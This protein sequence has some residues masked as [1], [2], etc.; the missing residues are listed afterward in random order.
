MTR[1]RLRVML[2]AAPGVGKTF[3]MLEEGRRLVDAGKDVVVAVV[4]THGRAATAALLDGLEVR[5]APHGRAPR[6]RARRDGPRRRARP[7]PRDRPRRRARPHQRARLP[8]REALAGRRRAARRRHRRD[9]DRQHPAH[10]VAQRRRAAD[11]RRAAARDDPG[12]GAARRRPDRARRPRP[13]G[14]A[15]PARGGPRLPGG[16]GRCGALQLLPA[17]QPH[18]AARTRAALARRRGRQRAASATAPSRASTRSGRRA[19]ASSSPSPAARRARPCC[20]AAPASP[21][22]RPA[23]SSSRC[24]STS[25]DGLREA[26]PGALAAQRALVEQLGGTYHQVVGE[27]VPAR[28]RRLRAGVGRHPA[29]DRRQPAQPARGRCS[30]GRASARPS[31][32]SPAT[33]TCTS[34]RTRRPADASRCRGSAAASPGGAESAGF[35]VALVVGPLLTR[36]LAAFR[37]DESI[38]SDVLAYQLL[39]VDR[40][41]GRRHLAGAVRRRALG[42]QPRLL[43]RRAALHASPSATRCTC[44]RSS[45]SWSSRRSSASSSTRRRGAPAS[46]RRAREAELLATVAGSVL[47]GEDALQALVSRT[48]E[49]F[50]LTSVRLL[51][52]GDVLYADRRR[53]ARSPLTLRRRAGDRRC[54]WPTTSCSSCP[55][56]TSMPR[57]RRLLGGHRRA[58]RSRRSSTAT[59]RDGRGDRPAR[60]GRPAAQRP[61]RR[62]RPRPAPPAR[63]GD[64]RRHEPALR[65]R[66]AR[67]RRPRRAARHRRGEPRTR[68]P[69]LVTDLLDVSRVQAGVLGVSLRRRRRRRRGAAGARR[70]AAR[71]RATSS[72][73][74]PT[75]VPPVRADAVLLQ[76]VVVNLLTQRAALLARRRA[77]R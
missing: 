33:S 7:P 6:R 28:P 48:R 62:R 3:A 21:R 76:R 60:R 57:D 20:A 70:A 52:G 31:S 30:P 17:R 71:A 36:L 14:A 67:R 15:R 69:T 63:R 37:S 9:L 24:T 26:H 64:G 42:A 4:E 23:A 18:G 29:R 54:R 46:R 27:D 51:D 66:R 38:T 59:G 2:G 12:C 32:A 55:A 53:R 13:A 10:R 19:S 8:Q 47:R 5:A 11:H 65:R 39:V 45:S 72:S 73:T 35:A 74:S 16:A 61:A 34:S 56:A 58:A 40:R 22:A 77:R 1:G 49:A 50:G 68:S 41:A 75:D 25:Q 44:S 43:L